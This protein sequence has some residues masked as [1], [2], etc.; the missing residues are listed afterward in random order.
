MRRCG[1][2]EQSKE[3]RLGVEVLSVQA[4]LEDLS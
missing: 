4:E 2:E 3:P 1:R